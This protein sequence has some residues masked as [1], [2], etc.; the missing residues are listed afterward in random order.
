MFYV[1]AHDLMAIGTGDLLSHM[2]SLA[3]TGMGNQVEWK[4]VKLRENGRYQN[5]VKNRFGMKVVWSIHKCCKR[6]NKK[7]EEK[8]ENPLF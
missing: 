2:D 1:G 4:T 5:W 3:L 7:K 8:L 6:N